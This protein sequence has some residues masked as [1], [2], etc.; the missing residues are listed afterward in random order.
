MKVLFVQ[1]PGQLRIEEM[2]KPKPGPHDILCKVQHCGICATDVAIYKGTLQLGDGNDPIY[3]VRLGHEWSGIVTEV[4]SETW[5]FKV[6]DRVVSDTGY[7]CGECEMCKRGQ[8][9]SCIKGKALGTIRNCWPGALAEYILIPER[10]AFRVPDGVALDVA[11]LIEPSCIGLYG[12]IRAG[13]SPEMN[14]L[15]MGTGPIA[16]GGMACARAMGTGRIWLAGRKDKKL[17]IGRALGARNTIN[18]TR[19]NLVDIVMRETNG[20]GMDVIMDTTGAPELLN[21]AMLMLRGSGTLVIPA[22]YEQELNHVRLDRL[23][24]KNCT[25]IGAA[26][27][28]NMNSKVLSLLSSGSLDLRPMITD[29][30]PFSD[31]QNAFE[32]VSARNATRV[33]V[34][35]DFE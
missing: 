6:G 8:Y 3:P 12:L 32:A 34:M 4:G 16:L 5:Q 9:Q 35:V 23:I 17:E 22:F 11:A 27:T 28:P 14:I 21:D 19:E 1:N 20:Q 7:F 18:M 10:M 30:F 24:V 29:R 33:K 2:E 31:V 13:I 26:G 15:I 25:L